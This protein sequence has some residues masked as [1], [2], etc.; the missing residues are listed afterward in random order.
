MR[1]RRKTHGAWLHILPPNH[2]ECPQPSESTGPAGATNPGASLQGAPLTSFC[3]QKREELA[4]KVAE[5]RARREEEARRLEA[6]QARRREEQLR[7]QAEEERERRERGGE[8]RAQKQVGARPAGPCGGGGGRVQCGGAGTPSSL[9]LP[10]AP[11]PPPPQGQGAVGNPVGQKLRPTCFQKEEEARVREEAERVRQERE[12]HFQREEQERLERKK[13]IAS[14]A[15][16][17][18]ANSAH[19]SQA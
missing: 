1:P 13:V 2:A 12:K 19:S 18:D 8:E 10:G 4:Q 6:E 17:W 3:R 15:E 5:E 14:K 7:L 11:L 9:H 16:P